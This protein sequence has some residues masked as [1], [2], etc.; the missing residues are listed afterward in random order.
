MARNFK[1]EFK[2]YKD[3]HPTSLIN[4]DEW[5][6]LIE[7]IETESRAE[8]SKRVTLLT[9]ANR[10]LKQR[11]SELTEE[12]KYIQA[13]Y[14]KEFKRVK[15]EKLKK[16]NLVVKKVKKVTC[17]GCLKYRNLM[18]KPINRTYTREVEVLKNII[19]IEAVLGDYSNLNPSDVKILYWLSISDYTTSNE[20]IEVF[21]L[22]TGTISKSLN[23]LLELDY[24]SKSD[25]RLRKIHYFITV[26]GQDL[27]SEITNKIGRRNLVYDGHYV[28][29]ENK[30]RMTKYRN[31]VNR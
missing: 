11:V 21:S 28:R 27:V 13:Y 9:S 18:N 29:V 3:T 14:E 17:D 8:L 25:N 12:K 15:K 22:A 5:K 24:I 10:Y 19:A 6:G 26:K 4:F 23:A 2:E 30:K 20:L 7:K 16:K 31:E 1:K